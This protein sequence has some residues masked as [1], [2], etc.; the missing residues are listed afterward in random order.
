M[1]AEALEHSSVLLNCMRLEKLLYAQPMRYI[2]LLN[3]NLIASQFTC[4]ENCTHMYRHEGFLSQG[5]MMVV[6]SGL[7]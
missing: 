4:L 2:T 7:S 3:G 5:Q 1:Y 6:G